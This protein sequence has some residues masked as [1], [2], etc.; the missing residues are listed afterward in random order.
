M[1]DNV[2]FESKKEFLN[3][4]KSIIKRI[5]RLDEEIEKLRT[6]EMSP[7]S[8]SG[9]TGKGYDVKDLSLYAA[10]L[11]EYE[12]DREE[13]FK[14]LEEIKDAIHSLTDQTDILI[15]EMKYIDGL[16]DKEISERIGLCRDR[17]SRRRLTAIESIIIRDNNN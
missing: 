2:D 9:G 12:T 5:R 13:C 6:K 4:Y 7:S 3:N 10:K 16:Q 11:D 1:T 8:P 15:L 14:K 17:I